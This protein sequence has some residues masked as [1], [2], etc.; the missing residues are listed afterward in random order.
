IAAEV[1]YLLDYV[2]GHGGAAVADQ[3]AEDAQAVD[4]LLDGYGY[5]AAELGVL[6]LVGA[7]LGAVADGQRVDAGLFYEGRRVERI[8]VGAGLGE[9]VILLAAEHAQ[10]ALDADAQGVS[11]LDDLAGQL[12]VLLQGQGRA[13]YHDGG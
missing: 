2:L 4:A 5:L 6:A 3:G 1:V 8:G 10:L 13:V 11:V 7:V 9:D 12:Y